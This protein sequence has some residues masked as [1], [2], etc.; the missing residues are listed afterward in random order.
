M[1]FGRKG[2][3]SI[4]PVLFEFLETENVQ[5]TDRTEFVIGSNGSI[6]TAFVVHRDVDPID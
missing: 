5:N 2:F 3:Q 6:R 1:S 4:R